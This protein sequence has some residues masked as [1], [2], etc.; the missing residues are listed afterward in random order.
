M[1]STTQLTDYPAIQTIPSM[2]NLVTPAMSRIQQMPVSTPFVLAPGPSVIAPSSVVSTTAYIN[3]FGWNPLLIY[4]QMP[5]GN[6]PNMH[7]SIEA[8]IIPLPPIGP[9]GSLLI[10]LPPPSGHYSSASHVPTANHMAS[11]IPQ[12][13]PTT[14][15]L[16]PPP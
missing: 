1:V 12:P 5:G 15:I 2:S 4:N 10:D 3:P 9:P 13:T 7:I 11:S 6:V 16:A 14:S 8:I